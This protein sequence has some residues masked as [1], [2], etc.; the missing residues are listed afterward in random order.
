[1]RKCP[2]RGKSNGKQVERRRAYRCGGSGCLQLECVNENERKEGENYLRE[3]RE[4]GIRPRSK[5]V[6]KQNASKRLPVRME[7]S[8]DLKYS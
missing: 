2:K 1:M 8:V 4:M 6:K 3:C 7:L 5:S